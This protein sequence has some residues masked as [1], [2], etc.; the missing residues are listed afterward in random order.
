V[1]ILR[2]IAQQIAVT[3]RDF[4]HS[5]AITRT[6]SQLLGFAP[7]RAVA[8]AAVRTFLN[9]TMQ[10]LRWSSCLLAI[11]FSGRKILKAL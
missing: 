2:Q 9:A 11:R 6:A 10:L 8:L 4:L 5:V 3:R 7:L 1:D